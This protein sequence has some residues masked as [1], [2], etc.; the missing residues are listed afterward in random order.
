MGLILVLEDPTCRGLDNWL[1]EPQL[2]SQHC[3]A[4]E[5]PLLNPSSTTRENRNNEKPKPHNQRVAPT[6]RNW[7]RRS[8]EDSAQP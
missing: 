5:Q 4:H 3:R 8:N 1:H 6:C 7:R 2:P